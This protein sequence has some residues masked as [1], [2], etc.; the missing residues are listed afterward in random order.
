M[1][2]LEENNIKE[3]PVYVIEENP[4]NID[5]QSE[6]EVPVITIETDAGKKKSTTGL[7]FL[8]FGILV[9]LLIVAVSGYYYYRKNIYIGVPQSVTS[10]ENIAKLEQKPAANVRPEI[11]VT[12]DSILGVA[13]N[14]YELCGLRGEIT[15]TKP[16]STDTS[17]YFYSRCADQTSFDSPENTFLGTLIANGEQLSSDNSRLGYMAMANGNIVIGV[18]RDEKVSNYVREHNGSFFRQFILVSNGVLPP[19]FHLHGKVERRAFG[20]IKDKIYYIETRHKETMWDFADALREYGF[21]DAIYITGG[22]DRSYY[23]TADGTPHFIGTEQK[24]GA[25]E[26]VPWVVFKRR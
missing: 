16:D 14:F 1:K 13:M 9:A 17:V 21:I 6:G 15:F 7:V 12:R 10:K 5:G 25:N 24:H 18:A 4:E 26:I 8:L 2:T 22:N 20:R 3:K 11:I 19:R 23:R